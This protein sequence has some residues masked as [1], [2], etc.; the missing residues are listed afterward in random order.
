MAEQTEAPPVAGTFCWNELMT[1]DTEAAGNFYGQLFGWKTDVRDMG[2]GRIYHIFKQGDKEAG[3][4]MQIQG[5]EMEGVP[6][7][8][9]SYVTVD[10]VDASTSKAESLGATVDLPPTDIPTIGRFSVITD[11]TGGTL[12]LFQSAD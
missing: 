12:G 9:L 3:G 1:P 2:G 10:S 4:M 6:P 11:P 5:P 7:C 8:W